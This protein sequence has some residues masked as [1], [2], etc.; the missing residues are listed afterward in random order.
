MF[1]G[2]IVGLPGMWRPMWRDSTRSVQ[3]EAPVR[4]TELFRLAPR[5][6]IS[7]P[8]GG[9]ASR[10]SGTGLLPMPT[11][12]SGDHGMRTV[13]ALAIAAIGLGIIAV[14]AAVFGVRAP[15]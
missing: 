1:C 12:L 15:V 3:T 9:L 6:E 10:R 4:S 13:L 11:G 5:P 7:H 2:T 8:I 14:S